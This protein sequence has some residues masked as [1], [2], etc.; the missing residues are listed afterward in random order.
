MRAALYARVSTNDQGQNPETQLHRLRQ[1]CSTRGYTIV[2]E[3]IEY[4][5]G[6]NPDRKVLKVLLRDARQGKVDLVL[7]TRL[8]RMMRSS[9]HFFEVLE[10]LHEWKVKFECS[11]QDFT[12]TGSFGKFTMVFLSGLAELERDLTIERSAEGTVRAKAEGK[13]CHRPKGA[14]DTKPRKPRSDKGIKR[15]SR[16]GN[17]PAEIPEGVTYYN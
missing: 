17:D 14:K 3:Y 2:G 7:V 12:T 11:E 1:V 6:K 13:L 5:S 8:D 4:A 16:A 9:K 10:Q 15:G